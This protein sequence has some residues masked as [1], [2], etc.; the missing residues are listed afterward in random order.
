[1]MFP[2][3][4]TLFGEIICLDKINFKDIHSEAVYLEDD[5]ASAGDIA[6]D[7]PADMASDI[8]GNG[9]GG[10][11]GSGGSAADDKTQDSTHT[12]R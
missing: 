5:G 7:I 2:I 6:A 9:P 3:L 4:L 1:M 11:L 12:E 10:G 8:T